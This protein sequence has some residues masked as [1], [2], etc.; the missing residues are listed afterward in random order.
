MRG[1]SRRRTMPLRALLLSL[2]RGDRLATGVYVALSLASACA[3]TFA[4]VLLVALVQPLHPLPLPALHAL[5]DGTDATAGAFA[6][7]TA[8]F[9]LLRW[10]ASRLGAHL[11]G[12]YGMVLRRRVQA[13]LVDASLPALANAT[14]AEIANVLTYNTEALVQGLSATQQ[15][16]VTGATAAAS[17]VVACWVSPVPVLAM[18][19]LAVLGVLGSRGFGREQSEVSRAYVADMTK[20]FRHS[21]DFPR[22]LR[23][24]RSYGREAAERANYGDVASRLYRGYARQLE[25]IASGRLLL[26]LAAALGI[27]LVF[28]LAHRWQGIDGASLMAVCLLLGRL[29]P[30]LVAT[31]QSFQQLRSAAPALELW[32][33][34]MELATVPETAAPSRTAAVAGC[35]LRI[36]RLRVSPPAGGLDVHDLALVPGELTLVSGDSGIGKSCLVDVLAGMAC[37][38]VFV[39]WAGHEPLDFE[40][41]RQRVSKGAYVSQS[42][43][44]WQGTVREC[45][46]WAAPAAG[47]PALHEALVDVGLERRLAGT[48]LDTSLADASSRLSGGELQRLL[49][50][51]VILRQPVLAVLDEATSAL[52]AASEMAVLTAM[53]RRLPHTVMVVVSHRAGV[54]ALAEQCL[55][56]GPDRDRAASPVRSAGRARA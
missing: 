12:H 21:E 35:T 30:Y 14:S 15:L 47:E 4:T 49:L 34:Y 25:L 52:D 41:Y 28:A 3:G 44:P 5:G 29:L 54:A 9:A 43:R 26:E 37:P 6:L 38:D 16:F 13:R 55:V 11:L 24:V 51:Q 42:V 10:R 53:K 48:G 31:R 36:Q 46:L 40:A 19:L 33:H 27:A 7:V 23:H 20:L 39:A 18:P 1:A 56:I 22:R 17:L 50:A 2:P 45:L 8:V 32:Q